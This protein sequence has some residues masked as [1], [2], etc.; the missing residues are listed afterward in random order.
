MAIFERI[1][2]NT[3]SL[4]QLEIEKETFRDLLELTNVASI[5]NKSNDRGFEMSDEKW[6]SEVNLPYQSNYNSFLFLTQ[7][8]LIYAPEMEKLAIGELHISK[9]NFVINAS[10]KWFPSKILFIRNKVQW[11]TIQFRCF[12]EKHTWHVSRFTKFSIR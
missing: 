10:R 2:W 7:N 1:Y 8:M 11:I 3:R 5:T 9:F 6:V 12:N 4:I